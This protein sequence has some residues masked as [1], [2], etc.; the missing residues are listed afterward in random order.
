MQQQQQQQQ[1]ELGKI[2]NQTPITYFFLSVGVDKDLVS[3]SS[4]GLVSDDP[5]D[6]TYT[7]NVLLATN[8]VFQQAAKQSTHQ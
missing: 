6:G 4:D 2:D 7:W 3:S 8:A 5:V 1:Q